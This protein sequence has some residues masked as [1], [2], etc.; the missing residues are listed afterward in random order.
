MST[1]NYVAAAARIDPTSSFTELV[2]DVT[3]YDSLVWAGTPIPR[4]TLDA[5]WLSMQQQKKIAELAEAMKVEVTSGFL[6]DVLVPGTFRKYDSDV[7]GQVAIVGAIVLTQHRVGM[8][9][10]RLS[11]VDPATGMRSYANHNGEQ[12]L[13]L[14]ATLGDW[15]SAIISKLE[16]KIYQVMTANTGDIEADL[17]TL[18]TITWL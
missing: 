15:S 1:V 7:Q 4:S 10:Y 18:I 14:L 3:D 17:A 13:D 6:S 2:L 9:F 11:S 16:N 12:L 8:T 5:E